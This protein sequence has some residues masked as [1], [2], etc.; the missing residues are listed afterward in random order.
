MKILE[1]K[2]KRCMMTRP[3]TMSFTVTVMTRM[4]MMMMRMDL[5]SLP[6]ARGPKARA[7]S[8]AADDDLH[9]PLQQCPNATRDQGAECSM[10][11][12]HN[13]CAEL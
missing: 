8:E 13:V 1:M 7:M 5:K 2:M 11:L 3:K 12:G 9:L 4:V 10:P 6:R